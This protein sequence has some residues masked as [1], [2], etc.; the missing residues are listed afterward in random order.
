MIGTLDECK[1][2]VLVCFNS[3]T[4]GSGN[5]T[6]VAVKGGG[7]HQPAQLGQHTEPKLLPDASI[8]V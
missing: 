3:V 8:G 5:C 7:N 2:D 1:F 4:S 6:N